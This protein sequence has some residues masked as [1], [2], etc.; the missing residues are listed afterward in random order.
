MVYH[1]SIND[2]LIDI[3]EI[4]SFDYESD[5]LF[6]YFKI[7]TDYFKSNKYNTYK[8]NKNLNTNKPNKIIKGEKINNE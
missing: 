6:L 8:P 2:V 4:R 1:L 5:D 7:Y 3:I